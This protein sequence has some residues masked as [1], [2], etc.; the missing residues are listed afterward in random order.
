MGVNPHCSVPRWSYSRW[1]ADSS[2]PTDPDHLSAAPRYS[3]CQQGLKPRQR[4]ALNKLMTT[5]YPVS[6]A[7]MEP[8]SCVKRMAITAVVQWTPGM[9]IVS[10]EEADTQDALKPDTS[11]Q[12]GIHF[13][14]R[15][16]VTIKRTHVR[17]KTR[18]RRGV[19]EARVKALKA[20]VAEMRHS[21]GQ[22]CRRKR[23]Q[24]NSSWCSQSLSISC[25]ARSST[26]TSPCGNSGGISWLSFAETGDVDSK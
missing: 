9:H 12:N 18:R 4:A 22:W 2:S 1:S 17:Q 11:R 25:C 20:K 3:S 13:D 8:S 19:D 24:K 16:P 6:S 5:R 26:N 7:L 14:S 10:L 15:L 21:Q 23:G